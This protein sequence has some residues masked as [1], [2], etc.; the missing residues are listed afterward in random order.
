MTAV[1]NKSCRHTKNCSHEFNGKT[2]GKAKW[3]AISKPKSSGSCYLFFCYEGDE[4]T[5]TAHE[6]VEEAKEQAEWEYEGITN[7]WQSAP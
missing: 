3:A 1:I 2:L 4:L 6:S 5:D 7:A